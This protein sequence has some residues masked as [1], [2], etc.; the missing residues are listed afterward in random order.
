MGS[1][2]RRALPPVLLVSCLAAASPARAGDVTA[3][4]TFPSPS[5]PWARGYGAA[6]TSTWFGTAALEAEAARVPLDSAE[7]T[8][9]SFTANAL[10]APPIGALVPYV[11]FGIGIYRQSVSNLG[12]T[13][14]LR[15]FVV[16]AK[17]RLGLLVVRGDY[18]KLSLR[19]NP[20]LPMDRRVSIGA[21][22]T[23]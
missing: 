10:L 21:G 9:T 17:L 15:T 13:S 2:I 3:F 5:D 11:G 16:G 12:E 22:I 1:R 6:L 18:R 20:L 8:M 4:V 14:M 7:G 23:F 19:G